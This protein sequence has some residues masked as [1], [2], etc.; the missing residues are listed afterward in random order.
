MTPEE[1][2]ARHQ[3]AG[4]ESRRQHGVS[5]LCVCAW[6]SAKHD[7][8]TV[9]ASLLLHIGG[10]P[11]TFSHSLPPF[12]CLTVL[13]PRNQSLEDSPVPAHLIRLIVCSQQNADDAGG[14]EQGQGY[15]AV[16]ARSASAAI[17][18]SCSAVGGWR[19]AANI[20]LAVFGFCPSFSAHEQP[21]WTTS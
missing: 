16:S 10:Q 3:K 6:H 8:S 13:I 4:N 14:H 20:W 21:G 19:T 12:V 17:F 7:L 11:E 15:T 2:Q 18:S 5:V 1:I 9:Y